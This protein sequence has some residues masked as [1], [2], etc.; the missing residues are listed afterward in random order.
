MFLVTGDNNGDMCELLEKHYILLF[1]KTVALHTGNGRHAITLGVLGK[2]GPHEEGYPTA[3]VLQLPSLQRQ[4]TS[5][6]C[7][8]MHFV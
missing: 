7:K 1:Y 2:L 4:Q 6:L 3:P 5:S 8:G